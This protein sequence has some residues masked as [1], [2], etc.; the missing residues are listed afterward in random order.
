MTP[1]PR[2]M[3][4]TAA[5]EV[6]PEVVRT[7][8]RGSWGILVRRVWGCEGAK[9]PCQC[10]AP[11]GAHIK[12]LGRRPAQV[13]GTQLGY[14]SVLAAGSNAHARKAARARFP[15]SFAAPTATWQEE[16]ARP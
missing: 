13:G 11:S 5:N 15:C 9:P 8:D 3:C 4:V 2:C 6:D 7:G 1:R 16:G 12:K 10:G 14:L